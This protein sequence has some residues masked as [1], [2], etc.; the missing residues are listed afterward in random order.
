[1]TMESY[2]SLTYDIRALSK[3][4]Y[5]YSSSVLSRD[6]ADVCCCVSNEIRFKAEKLLDLFDR[7]ENFPE[8]KR[9]R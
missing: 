4:T 3:M 1:M 8:I 5:Q 9:L 2:R 7:I 6:D